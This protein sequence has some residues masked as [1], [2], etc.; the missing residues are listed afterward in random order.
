MAF[1]I[2]SLKFQKFLLAQDVDSQI[3]S[4]KVLIV[5]DISGWG[6]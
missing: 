2:R 4:Y 1:V 3:Y 5:K 6:R